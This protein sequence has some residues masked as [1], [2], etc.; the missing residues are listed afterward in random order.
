VELKNGQ[1]LVRVTAKVNEN[2]EKYVQ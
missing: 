2:S 1:G